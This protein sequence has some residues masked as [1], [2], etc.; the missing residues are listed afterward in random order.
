[1]FSYLTPLVSIKSHNGFYLITF[2]TN[3]LVSLIETRSQG[4]KL[5]LLD[6]RYPAYELEMLYRDRI[7]PVRSAIMDLN[8][9]KCSRPRGVSRKILTEA[10]SGVGANIHI[11]GEKGR[12][13]VVYSPP[14]GFITTLEF[15]LGGYGRHLNV[16]ATLYSGHR[17]ALSA[18]FGSS[19][20]IWI[21]DREGL[22]VAIQDALT[23]VSAINRHFAGVSQ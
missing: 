11:Q 15:S 12:Y 17:I 21:A 19:N 18:C 16:S 2:I 3:T 7:W 6:V 22:I 20:S 14:D 8:Y 13:E 23:L 1:M 10:A 9:P 5:S 4:S